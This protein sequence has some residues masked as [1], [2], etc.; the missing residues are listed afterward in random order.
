MRRDRNVVRL[1]ARAPG[2]L[3]PTRLARV[4]LLLPRSLLP[5]APALAGPVESRRSDASTGE[6]T[7][8]AK[9]RQKMWPQEAFIWG[10]SSAICEAIMESGIQSIESSSDAT[11]KSLRITGSE[12]APRAA[13]GRSRRTRRSWA[14]RAC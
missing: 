8:V 2:E 1:Q 5:R 7:R 11:V 4:G 9:E 3:T 13:S 10:M 14:R 6:C 12:T